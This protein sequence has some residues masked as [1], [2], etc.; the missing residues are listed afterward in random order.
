MTDLYAVLLLERFGPLRELER[1]R[2]PAS[3]RRLIVH[4]RRVLAGGRA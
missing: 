4:R 3:P 1:E 2:R